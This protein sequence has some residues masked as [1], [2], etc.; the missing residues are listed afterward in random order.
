MAHFLTLAGKDASAFRLAVRTGRVKDHGAIADTYE[1]RETRRAQILAELLSHG[2]RCDPHSAEHQPDLAATV[3][4]NGGIITAGYVIAIAK[5]KCHGRSLE[6][7]TAAE[8]DQILF[9][10]R[11]RI[12]AREGRGTSQTRNRSQRRTAP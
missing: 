1:A 10:T 9:T 5:N 8:L 6:S 12:A 7:L 3:A 11:N 2:R 4:A